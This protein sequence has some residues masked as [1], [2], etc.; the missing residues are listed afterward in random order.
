MDAW[1]RMYRDWEEALSFFLREEFR[2]EITMDE[3][4]ATELAERIK[5]EFPH[6]W[7]CALESM[8]KRNEPRNWFT[9]VRRSPIVD[10]EQVLILH[11]ENEWQDA[12]V[13]LRVLSA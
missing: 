6:T 1:A 10:G 7:T 8:D 11:H 5:S 12:L 3:Q 9:A 4:R 2:E 13:A